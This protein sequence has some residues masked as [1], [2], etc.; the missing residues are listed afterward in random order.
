[1]K[2]N[3]VDIIIPVYNN[4]EFLA[5]CFES[6]ENQTYKHLHP[7]IVNDCSTDSSLK[8]IEKY[9]ESSKYDVT[10]L[11]NEE[12]MGVSY[13]R[14][15]ALKETYGEFLTFLDADDI[16]FDDHIK[17]LVILLK[18]YKKIR[19]AVSG[20]A[21]HLRFNPK[22]FK[23]LKVYNRNDGFCEIIGG[24]GVEG[25]L[26]NKIFYLEDIKKYDIKFDENIY[27]GEDLL[28]VCQLYSS[29]NSGLAYNPHITYYYRPN[30]NSA[31]RKKQSIKGIK[32]K[33][34]NWLETYRSI[35]KAAKKS[36]N[37]FSDY[38]FK[39]L[40]AK[41]YFQINELFYRLCKERYYQ[42]TLKLKPDLFVFFK[43]YFF[44]LMFSKF[45]SLKKKIRCVF[46]SFY[47]C[48][49]VLRSKL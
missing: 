47:N 11:D 40:Y 13:S 15:E 46:F 24:N 20:G 25:F 39:L 41:Y 36:S 10:I 1:M 21:T 37:N 45:F 14:N 44:V 7:I 8:L 34:E 3:Y 38:I 18:K 28:F 16:M 22:N 29:L 30:K 32:N 17:T 35:T 48:I 4:Y 19:I 49:Y 23:K 12:N 6:I 5:E 2:K 9:K 27:M 33:S 42:E 31:L 43:N 26:W